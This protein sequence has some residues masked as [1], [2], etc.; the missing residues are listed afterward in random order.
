MQ[1]LVTITFCRRRTFL[2]HYCD[3]PNR[4]L[5]WLCYGGPLNHSILI[6]RFVL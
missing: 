5:Y 3:G 1:K 2:C 4:I 6:W